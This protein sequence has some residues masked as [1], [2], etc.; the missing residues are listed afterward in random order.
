MD[1]NFK[2]QIAS[3]FGLSGMP[4]GEQERMIER[5]GTLLFE[6]VVERAVDKMDDQTIP[7]FEDMLGQAGNNYQLVLG[8]LK[9]KVEG[10]GEIVAEEL[11]RLKRATSG[12]FA[13]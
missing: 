1:E 3:D 4:A 9:D 13:H 12:I 10:F 8:F 2:N 11:S 7:D 6:S 5:I